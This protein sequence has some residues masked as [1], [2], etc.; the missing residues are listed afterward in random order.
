MLPKSRLLR[1]LLLV[2][3]VVAGTLLVRRF[4]LPALG[5]PV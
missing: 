2:V 5:V 3:F 1:D 4:V